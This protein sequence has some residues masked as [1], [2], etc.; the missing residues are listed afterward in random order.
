MTMVRLRIR[1]F[2]ALRERGDLVVLKLLLNNMSWLKSILLPHK[3][4]C[5]LQHQKFKV[6]YPIWGHCVQ[7]FVLQIP[8]ASLAPILNL[9][10]VPGNALSN[11][12]NSC[13]E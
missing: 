9:G 7:K 3:T 11:T 13:I 12:S 6:C 5:I 10:A 8:S 4:L 2:S 1:S